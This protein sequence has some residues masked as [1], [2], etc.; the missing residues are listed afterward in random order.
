[1]PLSRTAT[2]ERKR[3]REE[4]TYAKNIVSDA[5]KKKKIPTIFIHNIILCHRIIAKK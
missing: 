5:K 2:R 1:M 4:M 3:E